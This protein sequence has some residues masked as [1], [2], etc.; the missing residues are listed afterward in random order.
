MGLLKTFLL[1]AVAGFLPTLASA[2]DWEMDVDARAVMADAD[3][4]FLDGGLGKLRYNNGTT[5]QLGRARLA[6]EQRFG[7]SLRLVVDASTWGDH[8]RHPIDLTEGFVEYRSYPHAAWRARLRA[9]AFY[10]PSSLEN[11][12][13]GWKSPYTISS[14][15]LN[16]WIGE[17]IRAIG[18][19]GAVDHLGTKLGGASDW[20]VFGGIFG[21]NDP[22]GV[23][24]ASHGFALHDRQTSLHGRVGSGGNVP[25]SSRQLF[26]EIDD[27]PG[28]YV[29]GKWKYLD[30]LE[31][32]AMHY[33][34]R[35]DPSV[36]KPSIGDFAWGTRFDTAAVRYETSQQLTLLTQWLQGETSI[37]PF[38]SLICWRFDA[39]A[40][41]ASQRRGSQM[42]TL[43][44]DRFNVHQTVNPFGPPSQVN[45]GSALTLAY[46]YERAASP[47]RIMVELMRVDSFATDRTKRLALPPNTVE[48]KIELSLRYRFSNYDDRL[49]TRH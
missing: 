25:V 43:R 22:A 29:G 1:A 21:W 4:S 16:T 31:A 36:P 27:R 5:V 9:G 15:A 18:V 42:I 46:A 10:P 12:G 20:Q 23:L 37:A 28:Y 14:S 3:Q 34:N 45:R 6:L 41:L 48:S 8:D 26:Y 49:G 33:D 44:Y 35:A 39:W 11:R 38:M 30:R 2:L 19:E 47:W 7:E 32:R 24:I 40:L 13:A 17:E